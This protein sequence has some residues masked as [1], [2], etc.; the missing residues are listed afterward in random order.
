MARPAQCRTSIKSADAAVKSAAGFV[1]WVL[2]AAAAT[3]G[4]WQLNNSLDDSGTDLL[5]GIAQASGE[6]FILLDP[7]V[8]FGTGIYADIQGTNVT[9]TVGYD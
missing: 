8:F 3:G 7:P 6:T 5:S 4:A 2:A 9:L 1:Y